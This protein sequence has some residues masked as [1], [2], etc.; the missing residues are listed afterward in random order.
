MK[1][2]IGPSV[3]L[4]ASTLLIGCSS[5]HKAKKSNDTVASMSKEGSK[6]S[7]DE[8]IA[9]WPSRPK[10][11]IQEMMEKYGPPT[12]VSEE[13][14]IWRDVGDYKRIMVTKMEI[15]HDFPMPHMDFL[16]HTVS[17]M[18]PADKADEL[19]AFDGS[20]T[21][22]RTAGEM[23]AR[24]DLEGHNI[25][26]LNLANDIVKNNKGVQKA[27]TEFGKN[28]VADF[29]GQHPTYVEKLQF[30]PD[31]SMKAAFPDS[32]V[33]P[34]SPVR[35][36]ASTNMKGDAEILGKVLAV[37]LNEVLAASAA[38]KKD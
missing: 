34:G 7:L 9:T 35:A 27:R 31:S 12:E 10:L 38:A 30:K 22:N 26:T 33:I 16:E 3:L 24:C 29:G 36:T 4:L 5:G 18:V 20:V 13:A 23:S 19:L 14:V 32:A 11:A 21:I 6:E 15:P 28:V 2:I 8:T 25:L 17:Y 1:L 37:D